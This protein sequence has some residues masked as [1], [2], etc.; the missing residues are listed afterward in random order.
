MTKAIVPKAFPLP[1]PDEATGWARSTRRPG[2]VFHAHALGFAVCG[3]IILDRYHSEEVRHLGDAQY[4]GLCPR[5]YA[6]A[7]KDTQEA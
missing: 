5:C 2:T 4:F 6:R 1:L 7:I 3:S